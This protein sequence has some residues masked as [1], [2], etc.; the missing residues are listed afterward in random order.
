[1]YCEYHEEYVDVDE[2]EECERSE[3]CSQLGNL[4]KEDMAF[5]QKVSHL[6]NEEVYKTTLATFAKFTGLETAEAENMT[7]NIFAKALHLTETALSESLQYFAKK[8]VQQYFEAKTDKLLDDCFDKVIAEKVLL[9]SSNNKTNISTIQKVVADRVAA[10][11]DSKDTYNNK[12]KVSDTMEKAISAVVESKVD[13]ALKEITT[14]A[15]DKFNKVTMKTMM[16]GM[17][18]AIQDNPKLLSI[19]TLVEE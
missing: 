8:Q 6:K 13:E 9:I 10:Y 5:A 4:K 2:C 14:E 3:H 15:I 19:L 1:M 16:M 17:A 18:K 12:N 7:N 11:F